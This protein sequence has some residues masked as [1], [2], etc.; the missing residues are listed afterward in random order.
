MT[1]EYTGPYAV[2]CL[3]C[4]D[5]FEV[6]AGPFWDEAHKKFAS[7]PLPGPLFIEGERCGCCKL[8][9]D[10]E[11]PYRVFGYNDSFEEFEYPFHD[12]MRAATQYLLARMNP[13]LTVFVSGFEG[14]EHERLTRW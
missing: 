11:A 13:L 2:E 8:R 9:R 6:E 10:P 5:I 12:P 14:E 4:G 3:A 1:N 7:I